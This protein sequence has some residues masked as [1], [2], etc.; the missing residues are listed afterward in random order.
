MRIAGKNR[1]K[2]PVAKKWKKPCSVERRGKERNPSKTY[3]RMLE[4]RDSSQ[5]KGTQSG[6]AAHNEIEDVSA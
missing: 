1:A 5:K 2:V 3:I 6:R 4:T